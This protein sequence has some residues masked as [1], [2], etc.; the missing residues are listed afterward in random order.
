VRVCFPEVLLIPNPNNSKW[1][2]REGYLN[3]Q[4]KVLCRRPIYVQP[5]MNNN[6]ES[7]IKGSISRALPRSYPYSSCQLIMGQAGKEVKTPDRKCAHVEL[8]RRGAS[9][10]RTRW[11]AEGPEGPLALSARLADGRER[12]TRSPVNVADE[13]SRILFCVEVQLRGGGKEGI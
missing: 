10:T 9:P 5:Q 2:K 6:E 13:I 8:K 1:N 7:V 4:S 3:Y 11:L 12:G